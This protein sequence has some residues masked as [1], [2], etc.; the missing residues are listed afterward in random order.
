VGFE[1][2][3]WVMRDLWEP[4]GLVDEVPSGIDV[5]YLTGIF[6]SLCRLVDEILASGSV[7]VVRGW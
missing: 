7:W 6:R 2:D 3:M 5:G 4:C 1:G